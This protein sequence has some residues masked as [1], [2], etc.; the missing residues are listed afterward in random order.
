MF[1]NFSLP[2]VRSAENLYFIQKFQ[3]KCFKR[4]PAQALSRKF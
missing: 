2:L 3:F 1:L 4:T